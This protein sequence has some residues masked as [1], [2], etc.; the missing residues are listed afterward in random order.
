MDDLTTIRDFGRDLEHEPPAGLARQR[1]RL[2]EETSGRGRRASPGPS[3]R[4]RRVTGRTGWIALVAVAAVTTALVVI[5]NVLLR[6]A[7]TIGST[8]SP[9]WD[10]PPKNNEALNV[11]VLGTDYRPPPKGGAPFVQGERSDLMMLVHLPADR[12]RAM[13]VSLPRDSMVQIPE[14]RSSDGRTVAAHLGLINQAYSVGGLNCAWKTVEALTGVRVDHALAIRYSGLEKVVDALGGVEVR[15]P[16]AVDEPKSKLR[17]PAGR[18]SVDGATAVAYAR[19]RNIGDGSDISRIKRNSILLQAMLAK[20]S[21]VQEP[22]A[23]VSLAQVFRES[24]T[25]DAALDPDTLLGLALDI[26]QADTQVSYL[27]VP[28]QPF[29]PEPNRIEWKQPEA[30]QLFARLAGN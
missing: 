28:W 29:D 14:C 1:R 8:V 4:W 25:A 30:A 24:V 23:L 15:L 16:Q 2:L 19:V 27:T 21:R 3:G 7:T 18:S 11:L 20:L 22:A 6:G 12:K 17:L 10:R 13:V 26:Q 5:P 9:A